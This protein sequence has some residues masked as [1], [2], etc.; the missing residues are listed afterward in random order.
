MKLCAWN[1]VHG[2]LQCIHVT[3]PIIIVHT[4]CKKNVTWKS[5]LLFSVKLAIDFGNYASCID[6]KIL[7]TNILLSTGTLDPAWNKSFNILSACKCWI[8]SS[9]NLLTFSMWLH[10]NETLQLLYL[11]YELFGFFIFALIDGWA[12]WMVSF[13]AMNFVRVHSNESLNLTM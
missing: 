7:K 9:V 11:Q 2:I 12:I 4:Y 6:Y 10:C 1:L 13:S 8:N 5:N 3:L